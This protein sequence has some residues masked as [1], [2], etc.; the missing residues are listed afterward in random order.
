MTPEQAIA[1]GNRAALELVET[2]DA[3]EQ[4]KALIIEKWASTGIDDTATREKLF[5]SYNAINMVRKALE[6]SVNNGRV[7]A[8][9]AEMAAILAP[10][11]R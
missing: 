11:R 1:K 10:A 8:H 7:E 4:M 6:T 3:F 9:N 2:A 5:A